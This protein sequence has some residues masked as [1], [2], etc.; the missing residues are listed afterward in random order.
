VT[1]TP[2]LARGGYLSDPAMTA[3]L[4]YLQYW[5]QPEYARLL[6][7]PWCLHILSLL[8]TEEFRFALGDP[9]FVETLRE[10]QDRAW[11]F[12]HPHQ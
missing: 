8:K 1:C 9:G 10:Q 7:F 2:D 12:V 6:V 11:K 5:Y 4:H 3:Y